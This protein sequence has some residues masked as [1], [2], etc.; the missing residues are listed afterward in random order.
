MRKISR[1]AIYPFSADS[2]PIAIYLNRMNPFY[3][4]SQLISPSGLGLVGRDA[5]A[6]DNRKPMG[7]TVK[8]SIRNLLDEFDVL[9]ITSGNEKDEIHKRSYENMLIGI[10]NKKDIICAMSIS[11]DKLEEISL[12]SQQA[13]IS[14]QYCNSRVKNASAF[15]CNQQQAVTLYTPSVPV[16]FIG[17]LVDQANNYEILLSTSDK[18]KQQGYKVSAICEKSECELFG[19]HAHPNFFMGNDISEIDKIIEFNKF[20]QHIELWEHPDVILI[21]IPGGMMKYNNILTN[22]FGIYAYL[23]SQAIQPDYFICCTVY[24]FFSK[25]FSSL[26]SNDFYYKFGFR[27]DCFHMSNMMMDIQESIEKKQL[28][29]LRNPHDNIN[30]VVKSC[31]EGGEIP[32]YDLLNELDLENMFTAMMKE[33]NEYKTA[34]AI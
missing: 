7:I 25:E 26:I 32:I 16:I 5:S 9:L 4:I 21:Q 10:E 14:F 18:L 31:N 29:F 22:D 24:G 30:K 28:C 6:A 13:N 15:N 19:F 8:G 27:I 2:I 20:V 3:E 11:E 34:Y 1:I 17:G 23:I 33:L 12:R